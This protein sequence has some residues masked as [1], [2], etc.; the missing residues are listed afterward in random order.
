MT[1]PFTVIV[2]TYNRTKETNRALSSVLA[3]PIRPEEIIVV[4]DASEEPFEPVG[5]T[6]ETPIRI[7]RFNTNKGPS[8]ARNAGLL[9]AKT[10]WI[11]FLDSDDRLLPGTLA[12]RVASI[13]DEPHLYYACGWTV[14][15]RFSNNTLGSFMPMP[16]ETPLDHF[17]GVWFC[18]GSCVFLNRKAFLSRVGPMDESLRRFEDYDWFARATEAKFEL[19]V[20]PVIG[21]EIE[22]NRN[23]AVEVATENAALIQSKWKHRAKSRRVKHLI[24]AYMLYELAA[25]AWFAG[26]YGSFLIWLSCSF[27]WA[28]R[29]S[30]PVKKGAL[31]Y[32]TADT[33]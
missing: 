8:A 10:D 4:D 30:F 6:S 28:P 22:R 33:T 17:A 5:R 31:R 29:V 15:D 9:A 25:T 2:P 18:P 24:N 23:L 3:E 7:I 16:A 32:S 26:R 21:V 13:S 20:T 19:V 27:F 12:A 1:I 14:R 11:T